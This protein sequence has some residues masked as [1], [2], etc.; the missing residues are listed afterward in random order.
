[1]SYTNIISSESQ[2][3][4]SSLGCQ[5]EPHHRD[6]LLS[7]GFTD[8]EID[9]LISKYRV[10]SLSESQ[11]LELG[12][13]SW[14]GE[15]WISSSGIFFPFTEGFGQLRADSPIPRK[16]GKPAKYLTQKA[17]S[18]EAF[19]P[20]GCVAITEG[21]KDALMATLRGVPTGAIAGVSHYRKALPKSCKYT[22]VFDSDGW[23][24]PQVFHNL[25]K[26]G[27]WCR[28]K[29][30]I[31]DPMPDSPKG[32]LCE[33]YRAGGELD[34]SKAVKPL[35]LILDLPNHWKDSP[36]EKIPKL[37]EKAVKL[38]SEYLSDLGA[39]AYIDRLAKQHKDA[40]LQKRPLQK[41]KKKALRKIAEDEPTPYQQDY[42]TVLIYFGDRIKLNEVKKCTELDGK[43]F[44]PDSVRNL[45]L[46]EHSLK[47]KSPKDSLIDIVQFIGEG[48]SYNP[49]Q[50]YLT[51]VYEKYKNQPELL[52]EVGSTLA[53]TYL[54]STD[55]TADM[56]LKKTL[57]SAVARAFE[58]GSK[59]DTTTILVGDQGI[60]KSTFWKTLASPEYFCDDFSDPSNK[61]HILKLHTNWIIE[62]SELDGMRKKEVNH[63]KAFMATSK[64][65][66]RA[67][68]A[69][70][71]EEMKRP[72][73][74]VG[75]TNESEFLSDATG[76]RRWWIIN[77]G[78]TPIPIET[79]ENNR[80]LIW[81][82]AMHYYFNREN[83]WLTSDQELAIEADRRQYQKLDPWHDLIA[84]YLEDKNQVSY[85]EIFDLVLD[86]EPSK[87]DYR[88]TGR[89][90]KILRLSGFE[91]GSNITHQYEGKEGPVKKRARV[92]V[93]KKLLE[94][95]L[96]PSITEEGQ[97]KLD[98]GT[99]VDSANDLF[100]ELAQ[101]KTFTEK[102]FQGSRTTGTRE[103]PPLEAQTQ[104]KKENGRS[105][106]QNAQ[107]FELVRGQPALVEDHHGDI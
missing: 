27:L 94:T 97:K 52:Q 72:S 26:A 67:P 65:L 49:I 9:I 57:I 86:I 66:I 88:Y 28:G 11:A 107:S 69:R 25:I 42:N 70:S 17:R 45:L 46:I 60:R 77:C 3:A 105:K 102:G 98:L 13:K 37:A 18:S 38:A 53:S 16:D 85:A 5:L 32:G 29:V 24:N 51:S 58:P 82:A 75:T 44:S 63:L 104:L 92:W 96:P 20:E 14:D 68:Y 74:L 35:D 73:I 59:V 90:Q 106:S 2:N 76:N 55:P 83:W 99:K 40:G 36:S 4:L 103:Q 93:R 19:I 34:L 89:I 100:H 10:R 101:D 91:N 62:W 12:F 41:I 1:M 71:A 43:P 79:V 7:E 50:D 31:L 47:L 87:R 48:H 56:L 6:N 8:Q 81:A 80:D 15:K 33:L 61:D 22:I 84:D 54:G 39:E 78:S 64:D 95:P 23:T 21:F 30:L